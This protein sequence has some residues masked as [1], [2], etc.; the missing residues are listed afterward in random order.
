MS[1]IV[2]CIAEFAPK[3][4][5]EEKLF[6]LLTSLEPLALREDGCLKYRVT[7]QINH[8][9]ANTASKFSLVFHEEW[10]SIDA[11][12]EHGAQPYIVNFFKTYVETPETSLVDDFSLRIFSDEI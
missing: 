4:G 12:N 2:Y 5:C 7:R 9:A 10:A 6:N 11:F 8:P 1:S 3:I